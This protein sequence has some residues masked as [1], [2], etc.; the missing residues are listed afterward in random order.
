ML[1]LADNEF[2]STIFFI[3]ENEKRIKNKEIN[4]YDKIKEEIKKS[5]ITPY[6]NEY[7]IFENI[8]ENM[9][10]IIYINIYK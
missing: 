7:S 5:S 6:L 2:K 1:Y 3:N 10:F 8:D 9:I 4:E